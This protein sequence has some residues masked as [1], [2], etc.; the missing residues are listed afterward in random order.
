MTGYCKRSFSTLPGLACALLL[1]VGLLTACGGDQPPLELAAG[2]EP[3][4]RHCASCHGLNG[5]GRPPTF[6]PLAGSEWMELPSEA[7]ALIVLLGLRGEIEVA[8]RTYRGY[9]PPMQHISDEDIADLIGF[10]E[11]EWSGREPRLDAADIARIRGSF[12]GR[13]P[14]LYRKEGLLEALAELP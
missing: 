6:P 9:M 1:L 7:L 13:R 10:T 12:D 3:Y 11:R 4:L 14:P 8:G 2:Q 5:E